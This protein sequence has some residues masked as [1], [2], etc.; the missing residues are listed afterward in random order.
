MPSEDGKLEVTIVNENLEI[1]SNAKDRGGRSVPPLT[2]DDR[3]LRS[4]D[5]SIKRRTA[6][7]SPEVHEL[8]EDD[9]TP[10]VV[11]YGKDA[12]GNLDA[13]R[14][15]DARIVRSRPFEPYT[16]VTPQTIAGT[17]K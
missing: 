5:L 6:G 3:T 7:G 14:T 15:D 16:H 4:W 10:K 1:S 9:G 17:V 8:A 2:E 12:A 13:L 11:N